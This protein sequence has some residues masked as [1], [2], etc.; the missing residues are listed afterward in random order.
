MMSLDKTD[1]QKF[2]KRL[3]KASTGKARIKYY[4]VG[5]YGTQTMRPHYH[6]I[7]FNAQKDLLQAAWN[8]GEIH[9]GDVSGATIAYTLKYVSKEGKIPQHKNDM[10][11]PEFSLMSKGLGKT[12]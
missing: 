10:R 11:R 2:F 7:L 6:I 12:I 8:L 3:R 1:V 5:E 4:A 9:I